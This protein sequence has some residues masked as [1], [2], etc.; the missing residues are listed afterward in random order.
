[1]D[2]LVTNHRFER[3]DLSQ[4]IALQDG[5]VRPLLQAQTIRNGQTVPAIGAVPARGETHYWTEQGLI[6]AD[7]TTAGY[8][9][10]DKPGAGVQ[11][12]VRIN[13]TVARF[14]KVAS[15]TDTMAATWTGA[16]SYV[17]RDGELERLFMEALDFD[18]ELKLTEVLNEIEWCLVN[19]DAGNNTSYSVPDSPSAASSSPIVSQFNGLLEV[20]L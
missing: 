3:Q 14:S 17:L 6:A 11:S 13:N 2:T 5:P 9:Q 7:G 15:V 20:L 4:M 18:T 10:G 12:P 19:G 1:M 16:G 8:A